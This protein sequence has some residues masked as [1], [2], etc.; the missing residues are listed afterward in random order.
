MIHDILCFSGC[1][2]VAITSVKEPPADISL[3]F[4]PTG[5]TTVTMAA[6]YSPH[7]GNPLQII[8]CNL[9]PDDDTTIGHTPCYFLPHA[10]N[11]NRMLGTYLPHGSSELLV[12][13]LDTISP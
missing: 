11:N 5:I 10:V 3:G 6:P 12:G 7:T 2:H 4:L 13:F 8:S 9:V 1:L